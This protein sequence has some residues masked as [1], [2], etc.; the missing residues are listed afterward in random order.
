MNTL[1]HKELYQSLRERLLAGTLHA[2]TFRESVFGL[3]AQE[4][5]AYKALVNSWPEPYLEQL[6][7]AGVE[8]RISHAEYDRKRGELLGYADD[9]HFYKLVLDLETVCHFCSPDAFSP[10][11]PETPEAR[12][13]ELCREVERLWNAYT[14]QRSAK[15]SSSG[16]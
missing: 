12:A 13:Q 3:R 15:T 8:H 6:H 5:A 9:R 16:V 11:G 4:N 14:Q 1:A 10:S 7:Q 2:D